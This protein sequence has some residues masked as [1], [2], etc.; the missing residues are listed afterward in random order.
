MRRA[1]RCRS[2]TLACMVKML[3]GLFFPFGAAALSFLGYW[4][5]TETGMLQNCKVA[6]AEHTSVNK[7]MVSG[8]FCKSYTAGLNF[9]QLR[10]LAST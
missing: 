10:E 6:L 5:Q 8:A 9:T 3:P 1:L 2:Q 4:F 7:D